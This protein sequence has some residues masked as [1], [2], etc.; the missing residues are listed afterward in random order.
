MDE[1][2]GQVAKPDPEYETRVGSHRFGPSDE[3]LPRL[4]KARKDTENYYAI[5][6]VQTKD[7]AGQL[8]SILRTAGMT[9]AGRNQQHYVPRKTWGHWK[10]TV[11]PANSNPEGDPDGEWLVLAR[12]FEDVVYVPR[13]RRKS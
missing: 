13:Q 2:L 6:K 1:E 7:A 11:K 10:T 12:Y 8:A 9:E 4:E 3:R 5:E